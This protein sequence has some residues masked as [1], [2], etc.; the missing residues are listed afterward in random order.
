MDHLDT[1]KKINK[2]SDEQTPTSKFT[3]LM[4]NDISIQVVPAPEKQLL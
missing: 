1:Q 2:N 4:G 3:V